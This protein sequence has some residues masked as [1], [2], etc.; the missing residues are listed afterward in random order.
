MTDTMGR[1]GSG[2]IGIEKVGKGGEEGAQGG[3]SR[4]E[5]G[6][7]GGEAGRGRGGRKRLA[8]GAMKDLATGRINEQVVSGK[9]ISSKDG[10]G[11]NS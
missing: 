1:M 11:N 4:L 2:E 6:E 3:G 10:A 7:K 9:E 8:R 5:V